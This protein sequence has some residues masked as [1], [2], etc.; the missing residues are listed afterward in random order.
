MIT[1][2]EQ[3]IL[4]PMI[5]MFGDNSIID[6]SNRREYGDLEIKDIMKTMDNRYVM[7]IDMLKKQGIKIEEPEYVTAPG[8][9]GDTE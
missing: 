4:E 2:N 7:D 8:E 5:L 1:A 9:K 6:L 3:N